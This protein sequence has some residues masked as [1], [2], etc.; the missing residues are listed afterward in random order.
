[1]AAYGG[2]GTRKSTFFATFPTPIKVACFDALGKDMPY[3]KLGLAQEAEKN[4]WGG[5]SRKIVS[6]EGE[7]LVEIEYYHDPI[8]AKPRAAVKFIERLTKI[9]QEVKEGKINTFCLETV[10]SSM[11]TTRKMYQYDL[12]SEAK[13]PRKWYGGSVDVLEEILMIQLPALPCNV[14]IGLHVSKTKVEAEGSMVRAPLLPGRL[15]DSF[16]S[17]WPEIYR[18]YIEKSEGGEK[19]GRLQTQGDIRWEAASQIDAPDDCEGHYEN[20]WVNWDKHMKKQKKVHQNN[21]EAQGDEDNE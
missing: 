2:A 5:V 4:Q 14:C 8:V 7:V 9:P 10:S 16:S 3:W 11:L 13:D 19:V 12:E 6:G 15:M 17:Q 21:K 20:L 18:C 1:V